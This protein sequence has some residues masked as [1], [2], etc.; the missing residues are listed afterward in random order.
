MRASTVRRTGAHRPGRKKSR[1]PEPEMSPRLRIRRTRARGRPSRL[2]SARTPL[3]D[4]EKILVRI[5]LGQKLNGLPFE[6]TLRDAGAVL[7][8]DEVAEAREDEPVHPRAIILRCSACATLWPER[9]G[10]GGPAGLQNR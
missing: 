2:A 3:D 7:G 1:Q 6:D 8:R 4:G 9:L 10:P 5:G